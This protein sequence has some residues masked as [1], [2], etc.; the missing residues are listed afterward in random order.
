MGSLIDDLLLLARLDQ[1]RPLEQAPVDLGVLAV[2]AAAD[3]R[4]RRP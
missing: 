4:A 3:A 2:D 1:G